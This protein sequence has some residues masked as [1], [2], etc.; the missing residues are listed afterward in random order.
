[1]RNML[2]RKLGG[3]A[4]VLALLL[5]AMPAHADFWGGDLPLL[6]QILAQAIQQL[7][8]LKAILNN[9]QDSLNYLQDINQGLRDAMTLQST[10][11][12]TLKSGN[13]N[14]ADVDDILHQME[15]LY[16]KI[17]MTAEARTQSTHDM[18]VAES[19][20]LHNDAFRYA[21]QVDPEAE[22]IKEYAAQASPQG[23]AKASLQAQGVTIH[24][25]NQ[26]LRTNAALLKVQSEQLAMTNRKSKLQSDQFR[27]Q[28]GE[29]GRVLG[30]SQGGYD[31]P[32]L[33][34]PH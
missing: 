10:I 22:R 32:S 17:P 13:W 21:D 16:G 4:L 24:V 29:L 14:L 25:L 19:I 2:K 30:E 28:Y 3:A 5:P 31:L 7:A 23:A 8:Q 33:S 1:M 9:G 20:Q 18:T 34:D 6:A 26:I 11:N 27:Q 15:E 12:R